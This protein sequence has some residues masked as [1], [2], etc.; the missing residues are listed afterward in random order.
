M[1]HYNNKYNIIIGKETRGLLALKI[2]SLKMDESQ[3]SVRS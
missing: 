2:E 1:F 3:L